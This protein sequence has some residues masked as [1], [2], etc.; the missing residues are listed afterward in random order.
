MET[1]I[2]T[3]EELQKAISEAV[4]NA[5]T[6]KLPEIIQRATRKSYYTIDEVCQLLDVTRRHL[7]YL[8]QSGQISYVQ[9]GRK[10]YFRASDLEKFFQDNLIENEPA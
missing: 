5:V 4:Q 1:Y 10:I 6:E 3:K 8:R 9:N 2:S 7:L